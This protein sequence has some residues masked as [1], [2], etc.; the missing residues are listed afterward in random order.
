VP[1]RLDRPT[2]ALTQGVL[3]KLSVTA[4]TGPAIHTGLVLLDI[5]AAPGSDPAMPVAGLVD[6]KAMGATGFV[7]AQSKSAFPQGPSSLATA[8]S[9]ALRQPDVELGAAVQALQSAV[10]GSSAVTVYKPSAPL[11]LV[12]GPDAAVA[13]PPAPA[14]S[15]PAAPNTGTEPATISPADRRRVQLSLRR[16]GYFQGTVDGILG[17]ATEGA[18]RRYQTESQAEASGHLT[19]DQFNRLLVDGR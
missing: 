15:P 10:G 11:Y 3:A 9:I 8:F 5:V 13:T 18:I 6:E 16:L 2:D 1:A 19:V 14:P 17:A 4:T 7:A 12:G